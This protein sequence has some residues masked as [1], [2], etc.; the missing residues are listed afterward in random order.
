MQVTKF[1]L[2]YDWADDSG[3]LCPSFNITKIDQDTYGCLANFSSKTCNRTIQ[4]SLE[5]WTNNSML[6]PSYGHVYI[7]CN[8]TNMKILPEPP[9]KQTTN[10]TNTQTSP[11]LADAVFSLLESIAPVLTGPSITI[12]LVMK[13]QTFRCTYMHIK[14]GTSEQIFAKGVL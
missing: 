13:S 5:A 1:V 9:I 8:L 12:R 4:L 6:Q 3:V 14:S 10:L 7:N 11:G 2:L